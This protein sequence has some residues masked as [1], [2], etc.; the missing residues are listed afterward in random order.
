M[1][2]QMRMLVGDRFS[3]GGAVAGSGRRIAWQGRMLPDR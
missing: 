2:E 1:Q 3:G